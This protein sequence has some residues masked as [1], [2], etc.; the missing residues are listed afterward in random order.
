MATGPS[1]NA[2]PPHIQLIRLAAAIWPSRTLYIAAKLDV[3]D[4]LATRPKDLG[5]LAQRTGAPQDS[6]AVLLSELAR[7]GLV[8]RD[9]RYRLMLTPLGTALRRAAP[10]AARA[11]VLL[12][13]GEGQAVISLADRLDTV[14]SAPPGAVDT[15]TEGRAIK[16]LAGSIG[17]RARR[18]R[19]QG[20]LQG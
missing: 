13:A 19:D 1:R 14:Q 5:Q 8:A 15:L 18:Q 12:L 6:L 2:P 4:H 20:R 9:E 11:V 3:A 17:V 7:L 16:N 10:G